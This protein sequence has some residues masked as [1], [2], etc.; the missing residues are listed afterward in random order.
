MMMF[1]PTHEAVIRIGQSPAII[2]FRPIPK[3]DNDTARPAHEGRASPPELRRPQARQCR[4]RFAG[5]HRS[6]RPRA[7]RGACAGL[8]L[9]FEGAS[10]AVQA[11]KVHPNPRPQ[12]SFNARFRKLQG[13]ALS[14]STSL[15][16]LPLSAVLDTRTDPGQP[17]LQMTSDAAL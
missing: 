2:I 11:A 15:C 16:S 8:R 14:R 12:S 17:T 1:D 6:S 7:H 13:I 5:C 4:A 10:E 9:R 3:C